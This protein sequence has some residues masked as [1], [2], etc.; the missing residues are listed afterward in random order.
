MVAG[1]LSVTGA[2]LALLASP[3]FAFVPLAVGSGLVFAGA[4]D[5][6]GMAL[7]LSRLPYNRPATCDVEAMVQALKTGASPSPTR[8]ASRQAS[9]PSGTC[10]A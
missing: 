6:C 4:T 7:L 8:R 2:A 1:G 10:A 3:L 5:R 9:A